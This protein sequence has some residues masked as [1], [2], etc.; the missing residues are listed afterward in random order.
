[1]TRAHDSEGNLTK[2]I[3]NSA[4]FN[5]DGYFNYNDVDF[6]PL[7]K[8]VR[9][10]Y[11]A[12]CYALFFSCVALPVALVLGYGQPPQVSSSLSDFDLHFSWRVLV[13]WAGVY[14]LGFVAALPHLLWLAAIERRDPT[15]RNAFMWRSIGIGLIYGVPLALAMWF[16]TG[17]HLVRMWR[18][19][20]LA[21]AFYLVSFVCGYIVGRVEAKIVPL[22]S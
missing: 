6:W 5:N 11:C 19:W 20:P 22:E 21:V 7:V 12:L 18:A 8:R 1:M 3:L 17:L 10:V 16:I 14:G 15:G 13:V 4:W 9:I 2:Y